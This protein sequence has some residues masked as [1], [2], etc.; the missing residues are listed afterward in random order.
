MPLLLR[1]EINTL[2]ENPQD[3]SISIFAPMV[4]AGPETRQNP[5]RVKNLLRQVED[6]LVELGM[7]TSEARELLEPAW[8][9]VEDSSY[10]QR[11]G[12]GLAMFRNP[13]LFKVYRLPLEVESV[14]V[15]A[16]TFHIK[17]LL[18]LLTNDGRFYILALSENQARLFTATRHTINEVQVEDMPSGL[19]EVLVYDELKSRLEVHAFTVAGTGGAAQAGTGIFHGHPEAKEMEKIHIERYF[20]QID[21]ALHDVLRMERAPLV[22]AGVRYFLPIY[23]MVNSYPHLIP[24]IVEG[25]PEAPHKKLHDLHR[26]A[27]EIVEPVFKKNQQE[28]AALC[29][30]A[31]YQ[32]RGSKHIEEVLPAAFQSR[33]DTLFVPL[34]VQLWGSFNPGNGGVKVNPNRTPQTGEDDLLNLAAFQTYLKGGAVFVVN[35]TEMPVESNVAAAFRF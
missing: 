28:A 32:G 4:Q 15:V 11:Q 21:R 31:I 3:P 27:W 34:G 29:R 25:N 8:N 13:D 19:A 35:P 20:R 5:V 16:S 2:V 23:Q 33:V 7:R 30:M 10:W 26:E 18:P 12:L 9:L 14:A 6:R 1:E 17:P 24:E 22:L